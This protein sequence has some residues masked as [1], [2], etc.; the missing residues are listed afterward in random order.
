MTKFFR[1]R[2]PA[3][4][5]KK[6]EFRMARLGELPIVEPPIFVWLSLFSIT[7]HTE[8]LSHLVIVV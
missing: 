2:S 8:N 3:L 7:T 6:F 1:V 5:I 4:K